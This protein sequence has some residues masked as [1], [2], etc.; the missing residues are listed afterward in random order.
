MK[1][2]FFNFSKRTNSTGIPAENTGVE[3]DVTLKNG[4]SIYNPVFTVNGF[5]PD[6]NYVRWD[7]RYYYINNVVIDRL[8]LYTLS[9]NIDVLATYRNE[10]FNTNA[11]VRYSRSDYNADINDERLATKA[12]AIYTLSSS[13]LITDGSKTGGGTYIISYVTDTPTYGCS[14]VLWTN[15]ILAKN[16]ARQM[17]NTDFLNMENFEKQFTNAYQCLLGCK[18]VP[19]M[20]WQSRSPDT[21]FRLGSYNTGVMGA[22]IYQYNDYE[23]NITIPYKFNDFRNNYTSFLIYLPAYGIVNLS[24]ADLIGKSSLH[25]KLTV[26]GTTGEGTYIIDKIFKATC[27]FA[28]PLAVGTVQSNVGGIASRAVQT[29]VG[30]ATGNVL[31]MAT[32][33]LSF[34]TNSMQR[35]VGNIG[36]NGRLSSL[37]ATV[38]D[39]WTDVYMIGISHD[40]HSDPDTVRDIIGRTLMENRRIG[41]LSGYVQTD[42]CSVNRFTSDINAQINSYLNGGV[43]IE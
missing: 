28:V 9:C 34:M 20:W 23:C 10:I 25:I 18:Y 38:G 4:T 6:F 22:R 14:G 19:F 1:I 37:F 26:D 27:N 15:D 39:N 12:E 33:A 21:E 13:N 5:S 41:D 2:K 3:F 35:A 31:G 32:G 24:T 36:N 7:N 16:L 11:F 40:T 42:K 30:R 8:N 29:A 43:F 17:T